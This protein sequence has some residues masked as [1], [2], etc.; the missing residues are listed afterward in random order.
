MKI[1]IIL[2][3]KMFVASSAA[4]TTHKLLDKKADE[5]VQEGGGLNAFIIGAG[6]MAISIAVGVEAAQAIGKI[7]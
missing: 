6:Q 7:L 2:G 5:L 4:Y 3:Y 1:D